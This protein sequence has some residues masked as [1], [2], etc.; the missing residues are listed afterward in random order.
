MDTQGHVHLFKGLPT[1]EFDK[2]T[3]LAIAPDGS[4]FVVDSGNKRVLKLHL[5]PPAEH[6]FWLI[7]SYERPGGENDWLLPPGFP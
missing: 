6:H 2:P 7:K 1:A 5:I 3:A 4:V